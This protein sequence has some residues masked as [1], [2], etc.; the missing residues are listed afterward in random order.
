MLV[1]QVAGC[2]ALHQV[3]ARLCRWLLQTRDRNDSDVLPLT[4]FFLAEMLGVQRTT[5]TLLARAP[6]P[7]AYHLPTRSNNDSRPQ[8]FEAEACECYET[9]RRRI[10]ELFGKGR[11]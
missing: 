4:H 5:V 1:S 9:A 6:G 10:D 3:S 11:Q 2:N 7:G 8:E